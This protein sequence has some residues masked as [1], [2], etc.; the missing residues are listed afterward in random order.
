MNSFRGNYS[1]LDLVTVHKSVEKREETIQRRKLFA[2]IRY[3]KCF[4]HENTKKILISRKFAVLL[5]RQ[6]NLLK[7]QK[8]L[9]RNAAEFVIGASLRPA[10]GATAG[11]AFGRLWGADDTELSNWM[12]AGASLGALN[13]LVQR[14]GKVFST[15]EKNILDKI[16]FN[17]ATKLSF[18]KVRELTSTTAATKLKAFGGDTEKIGMKLFQNLKKTYIVTA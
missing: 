10:F 5:P 16:I 8:S 11:Y 14:S 18:Q 15:G 3:F 17:N 13:K 7:E 2:K 1:F 6:P 4:A 9:T 12:W